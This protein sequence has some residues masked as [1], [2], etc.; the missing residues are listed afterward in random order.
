MCVQIS[1]YQQIYIYIYNYAYSH[2]Q[3]DCFVISQLISVAGRIKL[4]LEPAQLYV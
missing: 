2:P 1:Q 4:G 3:T